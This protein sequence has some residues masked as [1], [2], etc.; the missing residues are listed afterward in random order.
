MVT[1]RSYLTF[2]VSVLSQFVEKLNKNYWNG[3]KRVFKHLKRTNYSLIYS[4]KR[5]NFN[6][7]L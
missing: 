5:F 1:N 7:I 4:V 6:C 2:I 3:V